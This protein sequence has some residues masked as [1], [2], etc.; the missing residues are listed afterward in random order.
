MFILTQILYELENL[1]SHGVYVVE[2][3]AVEN[4]FYD[5]SRRRVFFH[6]PHWLTFS[7]E[8][9][10]T[11]GFGKVKFD[12]GRPRVVL[13]GKCGLFSQALLVCVKCITDLAL[14]YKFKDFSIRPV[15]KRSHCVD[16]ERLCQ[17][18]SEALPDDV[19]KKIIRI[20][21]KELWM[22][23]KTIQPYICS[24]T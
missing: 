18:L 5:P 2:G 9:A 1:R 7:K 14:I 19:G 16:F 12:S 8:K 10:N 24:V 21:K 17:P 15:G 4:W 6:A 23:K 11:L 13:R 3:T 22:K 20:A